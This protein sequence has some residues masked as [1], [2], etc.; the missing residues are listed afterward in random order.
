MRNKTEDL[1]LERIEVRNG[2]NVKVGRFLFVDT[3]KIYDTLGGLRNAVRLKYKTTEDYYVKYYKQADEG[4]CSVCGSQT[5]FDNVLDGYKQECSNECF[6]RSQRKA[7]IAREIILRHNHLIGPRNN[8]WDSADTDT[9]IRI[10]EKRKKTLEDRHPGQLAKNLAKGRATVKAKKE[11]DPEY[12]K[13]IYQKVLA[14]KK[15]RGTARHN[16]NSRDRSF[17]LAGRVFRTQGYEDVLVKYL[18][19]EGIEFLHGKEVEPLPYSKAYFGK[20]HPDFYLPDYNLYIDVKSTR[21]VELGGMALQYKQQE[22]LASGKNFVYFVL[23]KIDKNRV[24]SEEDK[25][26]FGD[27]ISMLISSQATPLVL[28]VQRLFPCGST[29]QAIG[30]G[31]A[32]APGIP[33]GV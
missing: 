19:E 25:I 2:R 8:F 27:F 31:N 21:T 33:V 23:G 28:K 9:K 22:V 3:G 29:L 18:I 6:Q 13:A 30:S 4:I 11:S 26:E 10:D 32:E 16:S 14:T 15:Q 24:I 5:K 12:K 20:Y 1:I 7:D 17:T